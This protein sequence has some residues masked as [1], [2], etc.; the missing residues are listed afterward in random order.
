MKKRVVVMSTAL[1]LT[2]VLALATLSSAQAK[3]GETLRAWIPDAS[4]L[5]HLAPEVSILA[6]RIRPPQGYTLVQQSGPGGAQ[7]VAWKGA[8]RP[9]GT[10][11]YVMVA[12]AA[13]PPGERNTYTLEE[14]LDEFL[15]GV[16][17]RRQNWTRT[18][19]EHGQVNGLTFVRARWSGTEPTNQLKMHGFSYVT[20]HGQTVIQISSQDAEPH[21]EAALRLAEAAALTFQKR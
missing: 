9:D 13:P 8:V 4:L 21:P 14:V 6:F 15:A 19:S 3:K 16:Q 2:G 12:I 10:A 17:R 11:P 7:I 1:A 18:V 5:G 20:L